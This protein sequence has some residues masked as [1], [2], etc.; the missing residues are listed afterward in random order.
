MQHEDRE[1]KGSYSKEDFIKRI[2]TSLAGRAAEIV[3]YGEKDG[4]TTGASGDL[5]SATNLATAMLCSYGMDEEFGLAVVSADTAYDALSG[6]VR[7]RVNAILKEELKN[8]VAM[9]EKNR[10]GID[11]LVRELLTQNHLNGDQI[12]RL[13]EGVVVTE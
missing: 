5:Q 13:L 1:A 7:A 4:Y 3:Y 9:I 6:E 8:T 11:A 12:T 2:R 10:A